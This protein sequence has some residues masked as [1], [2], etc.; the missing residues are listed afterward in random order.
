ME[1]K[2]I[3]KKLNNT[4]TSSE[5]L[6]FNA[7]YQEKN[8]HRHF[9]DNVKT[10][11]SKP[12]DAVDIEKAWQKIE[13]KIDKPKERKTY[14]KFA[15]ASIIVGLLA[16]SYFFKDVFFNNP[17]EKT[18]IIVKENTIQPGTDKAVLT[19]EDGS[20]IALEKG[21]SFQNKN[22]NSNGK[23]LIYDKNKQIEDSKIAYNYLTI[24]RGGQFFIKLADGTQVW[25]NSESKLKYPVNFK[26]GEIRK[27]ELVYGEAYFDVSPSIDHNGAE[28]K[29]YNNK[30]EVHVLGTAFNIKAYKDESTINTTL[31]EGNVVLSY[32]DKKLSLLPNQQSSINIKNNTII[33][34]TVDVY[35]EISWK[36][37][38]F[39]FEDKSLKEIMKVLSRW[40][41][42]EVV[43]K[44]TSVQNEEFLG[45]LGKE[46]S[47]EEILTN[48]KNL[49]IINDFEITDK[50]VVLK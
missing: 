41:D 24:P 21:A 28:F 50:K 29:V 27:V 34:R 38:I 37:G 13:N 16:S 32:E 15:V 44:N 31:V 9:F 22:I 5:E 33:T 7:W 20:Q 14:W 23:A 36:E 45:V 35:N 1:F 42:M 17:V 11:Y 10:N 43:F 3:L 30:Q 26:N 19:L 4:I 48:I 49:G 12:V 25:L 40:Y 39:S 6:I 2:L 47:I 46:Q 8:E 18:P